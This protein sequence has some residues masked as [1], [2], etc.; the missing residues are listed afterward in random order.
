[1][2]A[3]FKRELKGYFGGMIAFVVMAIIIF[4]VSA[5]TCVYNI[6]N[7]MPQFEYVFCDM[8]VVMA[9]IVCTA[10]LAMKSFAEE[11]HEKTDRLL[12]SLPI[13]LGNVVMGKYFAMLTVFLIPTLIFCTYPLILS[14]FGE[15]NFLKTYSCIL[16]FF[17]LGATL[18]SISMF[19]SS[20]TD[21]QVIAVVLSFVASIAV[22]IGPSIASL[23]LP[24]TAVASFICFTLFIAA[25]ALAVYGLTKNLYATF[26][27]GLVLEAGNLALYLVKPAIFESAFQGMLEHI[28]MFSRFNAFVSGTFDLTAVVY[29]LSVICVFVFLTTQ[30]LEKKRY[31]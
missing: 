14:V 13:K 26:I 18:I 12:Y 10:L 28:S 30:T 29:Y 5:F 20:L 16:V 8:W 15:I 27:C 7:Q 23:F 25:I 2:K 3:I 31:C 17:L 19:M 22:Y 4:M 9:L 1:M 11:N 6:V 24:Q 21:N